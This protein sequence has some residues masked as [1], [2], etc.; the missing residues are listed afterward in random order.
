MLSRGDETLA[1]YLI[2]VYHNGANLG[3]FKNSAK[4]IVDIKQFTGALDVNSVLP[5]D[6]IKVRPEKRALLIEHNR[7]LH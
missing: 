4:G 2:E 6:F 5:W 1:D 7:L 3:A